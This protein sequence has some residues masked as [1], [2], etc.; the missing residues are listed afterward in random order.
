MK[1]YEAI[2]MT[3]AVVVFLTGLTFGIDREIA[4]RDFQKAV[5]D[6]DFEHKIVGCIWDYNCEYY[7]D[8]L[9]DSID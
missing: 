1:F 3:I 7:T 6:G 2:M 9:F 5:N 8:M 4:R